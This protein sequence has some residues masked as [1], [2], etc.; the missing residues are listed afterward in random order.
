M[1]WTTSEL[2]MDILIGCVDRR[3]VLLHDVRA[4]YD[5]SDTFQIAG[6]ADQSSEISY[7]RIT[8]LQ[9]VP[10][11]DTLLLPI[12]RMHGMG[13]EKYQA[14]LHWEKRNRQEILKSDT[15]D[16]DRRGLRFWPQSP[17]LQMVNTAVKHIHH[18][19]SADITSV[20]ATPLTVMTRSGLA[21]FP[22]FM[23]DTIGPAH[24]FTICPPFLKD[25]LMRETRGENGM[26]WHTVARAVTRA[27]ERAFPA[28]VSDIADPWSTAK[29]TMAYMHFNT[30]MERFCMVADK[31]PKKFYIRELVPVSAWRNTQLK[32]TTTQEATKTI[33]QY[34]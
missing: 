26:R 15:T 11:L 2:Q 12:N 4:Y 23:V 6:M 28:A 22:D 30:E 25:E 3:I 16:I 33:E 32:R 5:D 14:N 21:V 9:E 18:G 8:N 24:V 29:D 27:A 31:F 13:Y 17:W 1:E 34:T 20:Q 7:M 10:F 19:T